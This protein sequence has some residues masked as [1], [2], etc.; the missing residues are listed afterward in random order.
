MVCCHA[1]LEPYPLFDDAGDYKHVHHVTEA[2]ITSIILETQIINYQDLL[3][4]H[5]QNVS[6]SKVNY[7]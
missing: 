4:L 6:P 2:L 3:L 1:G 7:S 5:D